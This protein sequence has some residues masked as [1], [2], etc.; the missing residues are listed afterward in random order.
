MPNWRKQAS[1]L[2][3]DEIRRPARDLARDLARDA[4]SLRSWMLRSLPLRTSADSANAASLSPITVSQW[5]ASFDESDRTRHLKSYLA[6]IAKESRQPEREL[7]LAAAKNT[8]PAGRVIRNSPILVNRNV[9]LSLELPLFDFSAPNM[10]GAKVDVTITSRITMSVAWNAML[11]VG[12]GLARTV[13]LTKASTFPAGAGE[14]VRIYIPFAV[15]AT[16]RYYVTPGRVSGEYVFSPLSANSFDA[17]SPLKGQESK[18]PVYRP[19]APWEIKTYHT[20]EK[21]EEWPLTRASP[22]RT[23]GHVIDAQGDWQY[24]IRAGGTALGIYAAV[25]TSMS[26]ADGLTIKAKLPGGHT[27]R[28]ERFL[29]SP[30]IKWVIDP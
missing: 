23:S 2:I 15:V 16:R 26:F 3:R 7:L 24:S 9:R 13:T 17:I 22:H 19:L 21:L 27:Y 12:G 29:H 10:P 25:Q 1:D 4:R 6:T 30:G 5:L 8:A 28:L 11:G 20:T 18:M 14:T